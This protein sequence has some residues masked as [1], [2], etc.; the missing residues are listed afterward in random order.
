M[1]RE[2]ASVLHGDEKKDSVNEITLHDWASPRG[3]R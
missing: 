2:I 3:G 1:T